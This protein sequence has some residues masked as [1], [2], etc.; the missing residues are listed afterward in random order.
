MHYTQA[1]KLKRPDPPASPLK[2]RTLEGI[3]VA[4]PKRSREEDAAVAFAAAGWSFRTIDIPEVRTWLAP[5][6][7][8]GLDHKRLKAL[9]SQQARAIDRKVDAALKAKVVTIAMDGWTSPVSDKVVNILAITGLPA[10][11]IS[12]P[13]TTKQILL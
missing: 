3:A 9:M 2:Q 8:P 12:W 6:M 5:V 7:P 4:S 1:H 13:A 11:L 10:N